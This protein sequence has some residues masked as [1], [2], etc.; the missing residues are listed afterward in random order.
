MPATMAGGDSSELRDMLESDDDLADLLIRLQDHHW[1]INKAELAV[2]VKADGT[3]CLLEK[4]SFGSVSSH[5][6][7]P[8]LLRMLPLWIFMQT[9]QVHPKE[10]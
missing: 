5:H 10:T 1:R 7:C 8:R 2:C 9:V 3:D 4:G 6:C